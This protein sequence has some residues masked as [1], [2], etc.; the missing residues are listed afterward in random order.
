MLDCFYTYL[1]FFVNDS[2]RSVMVFY[3]TSYIEVWLYILNFNM[4]SFWTCKVIPQKSLSL[5]TLSWHISL[6]SVLKEWI[7]FQKEN[8][9][10]FSRGYSS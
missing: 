4:L 7:Q 8:L 9:P 6:F 5:H 2:S 3:L 10:L 1:F